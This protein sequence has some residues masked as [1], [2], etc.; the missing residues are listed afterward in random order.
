MNES[1][2][3]SLVSLILNAAIFCWTAVVVFRAVYRKGEDGARHYSSTMY[4]YFTTDSNVLSALTALLLIPFCVRGLISGG[5]D[6][7]AWAVVCK[8]VGTVSVSVTLLTVLFFLGPTQGYPNMFGG[9]GLYLHLIGPLLAIVS[10]C[11]VE[12]GVDLSRWQTL[13][14]LLPT[15]IYGSVY[16][17]M[18]VLRSEEKGGW[19]DFYGFNR[20][21]KWPISYVVM[22]IATLLISA[23]LAAL[24]NLL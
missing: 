18:A 13:L 24:H 9:D 19:G 5:F 3:R 4:R 22:H 20:G 21:G 1:T 15:F 12:T 7:P 23:G 6:L 11:A 10:F 16:L 17:V 14:G 2:L 8:Y